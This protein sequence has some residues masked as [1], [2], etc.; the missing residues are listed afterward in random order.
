MI[1]SFRRIGLFTDLVSSNG[2]RR[3]GRIAA[4]WRDVFRT[5]PELVADL[6]ERG[7]MFEP[8]LEPEIVNGRDTGRLAPVSPHEL[9]RRDGART[10]ALAIIASAD[11]TPEEIRAIL[12]EEERHDAGEFGAELDD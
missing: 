1:G 12:Q 10:L 2:R 11:I 5:H 3:A 9:A 4:A 7:Y 6:I 8:G